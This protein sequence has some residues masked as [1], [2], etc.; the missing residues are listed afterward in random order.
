MSRDA[1]ASG[2]C[3][4]GAVRYACGAKPRAVFVCHCTECRKQSSSAFGISVQV[5]QAAFHVVQ[6]EPVAWSRPTATG[7]T[8]DCW[9][10]PRCGSRLWHQ[11]R[12]GTETLN[13]KGGSLDDPVDLGGAIHI[14]TRS[15]L[16]GV[17]VP[18]NARQF[19]GE[20]D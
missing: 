18:A 3:Q 11:R 6:G 20:P 5:S 17:V 4:C 9:F 19:P 14:W 7:H 8:L 1:P 2:G 13:L 15:R 16:P 10:C 12:G